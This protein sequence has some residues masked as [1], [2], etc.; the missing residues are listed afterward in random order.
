[1]M[2]APKIDLHV[3]A[4]SFCQLHLA[5]CWTANP[6]VAAELTRELLE[7]NLDFAVACG[8]DPVKD[9][10]ALMSEL[11]PT[12]EREVKCLGCYLGEDAIARAEAVA[13]PRA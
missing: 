8:H 13:R 6:Q 5:R 12:F 9:T 11:Q 2:G 3:K 7:D 1:M 10:P 4:T